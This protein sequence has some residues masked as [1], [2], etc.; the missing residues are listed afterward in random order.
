MTKPLL[1]LALIAA[2]GSLGSCQ[3]RQPASALPPVTA[4][5]TGAATVAAA[6]N[7]LNLHLQQQ[8]NAAV[9]QLDSAR[10]ND[11]QTHWQVLVPRTDWAGRMPNAAAFKVDKQ[12]AQVTILMVK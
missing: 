1:M 6:R 11:E 8:T 5:P 10:F 9:F 2:L 7:A 4:A 3:S 12:T